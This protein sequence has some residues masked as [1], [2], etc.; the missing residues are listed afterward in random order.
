M[1]LKAIKEHELSLLYVN[2]PT[3]YS[4]TKQISILKCVQA[5]DVQ[6]KTKSCWVLGLCYNNANIRMV[7]ERWEYVT[8]SLPT[9]KATLTI[10][11]FKAVLPE[12][13]LILGLQ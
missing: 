13:Y 10:P 9:A 12:L 8:V 4:P 11:L 2:Q 1:V 3:L 7:M 5:F 6:C